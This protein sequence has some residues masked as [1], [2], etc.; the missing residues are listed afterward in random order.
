MSERERRGGKGG[1]VREDVAAID[2]QILGLLLKRRNLLEKTRVKGRLDAADEKYLREAW[3]KETARVSKDPELSGRFFSLMQSVSF[4]PRPGDEEASGAARR[5][6]FN[7]APPRQAARV[8]LP[9]PA[10]SRAT[11]SWLYTAAAAGQPIRVAPSAQSDPIVD[12]VQVLAQMGGAVT[13][14]DDA[15][16]C[17]KAA[18]MGAPDKVLFVGDSEFNFYLVLAHYLGRHSH[19]KITGETGLKLADFSRLREALT[20][21][22]A[23][24]VHIVPKS[25]GLPARLE[26]SGVLP[27]A[28]V[29]G[30]EL[31][32]GFV[33]ALLLAA[34]FYPAPIG[35]D[36]A[37]RADRERILARVLPIFEKCGA[38]FG[39]DGD[40]VNIQPSSLAIP[41]KPFLPADPEIAGFLLALVE[42]LG[43]EATLK[44]AWPEWPEASDLWNLLTFAGLDWRKTAGEVG[45]AL[46]EPIK[47][48]KIATAP[49]NL[50]NNLPPSIEPL[51]AALAVCAVL[52]KGDAD[53]PPALLAKEETTDFLRAAGCVADEDGK[54]RLAGESRTSWNAPGPGWAMA[55]AVAACARSGRGG[56]AL[57]NPGIVASLWPSWWA[58]Y[59]SLPT[60]RL[61]KETAEREEPVKRRRILT[62]AVATPPEIKEEDWR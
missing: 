60:P 20:A 52:N 28:L 10:D 49:E 61:K 14:E 41:A 45:V 29:A 54:L 6:A 53:L 42:A 1:S 15:V 2:R 59:N 47:R 44:G 31:P 11:R 35:F 16:S 30:P 9:L 12:F 48:F 55:L 3:Q 39:R 62:T 26:C 4:L 19:C 7:L 58:V 38:T 18:P 8:D 24:L 36:L 43:G 17:R 13:R 37:A 22:G 21:L 57:G 34:P 40:G 23:R 33:Q 51:L 27:P 50:L 46:A 25:S 32:A 56:F 5:D